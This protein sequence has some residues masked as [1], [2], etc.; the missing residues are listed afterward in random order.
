[1]KKQLVAFVLVLTSAM[2]LAPPTCPTN[3]NW[4]CAYT[5]CEK[6]EY[7]TIFQCCMTPAPGYCC[8]CWCQSVGCVVK[9]SDPPLYCAM[10]PGSD[11]IDRLYD[12]VKGPGY[13][14]NVHGVCVLAP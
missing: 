3:D 10:E 6:V 7:G 1:M 4:D 5:I 14:C 8:D 11:N 9:G 12:P 13:V 2:A